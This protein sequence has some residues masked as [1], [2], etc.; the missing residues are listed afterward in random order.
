MRQTLPTLI[1]AALLTAAF[2]PASMAQDKVQKPTKPASTSSAEMVVDYN[3]TLQDE[4]AKPVSGVFH[5]EFKLYDGQH[6]KRSSWN[7]RHFVAVVD[8]VY[9]VPLGSAKSLE[10]SLV[11]KDA[12]IGVE[13]VGEG[14]LLRDRFALSDGG[15]QAS[16][17]VDDIAISDET[18]KLL[19]SAQTNSKIAFADVAERAVT[20]DKAEVA[21]RAQQIGDLSADELEKKA[22][23]AL[24]RLGEHIADPDAHS[25][26][27]GIRLDGERAVQKR[28][29]GPGGAPYQVNCPPGYVVTGIKGGAGKLIDSVQLICQK[30]R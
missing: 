25:A 9:T 3:G 15:S 4:N 11:P 12:W 20:A 13:L 8:G 19:E 28:V 7:E 2:A 1:A 17:G 10:R 23:V 29:G 24:E 26:T 18:R 22:E 27:G 6:A 21:V 30:L 5:L 16:K 14:E